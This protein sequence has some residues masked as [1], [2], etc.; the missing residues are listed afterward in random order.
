MRYQIEPGV[1]T[2]AYL[3][4]PRGGRAP[5]PAVVVFHP[6]IATAAA[7]VVLAA[8]VASDFAGEP[9]TMVLAVRETKSGGAAG[10]YGATVGGRD[11][12]AS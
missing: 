9:A 4:K 3:L 10:E 2:D 11:S 12:V 1:F 6:T 5:Y 7:Q 8:D